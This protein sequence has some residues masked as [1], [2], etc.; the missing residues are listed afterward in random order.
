MTEKEA[1]Y[2]GKCEDD[3]RSKKDA[4]QMGTGVISLL[5]VRSKRSANESCDEHESRDYHGNGH[6]CQ[7]EPLNV[8]NH[9]SCSERRFQPTGARAA[10][11]RGFMTSLLAHAGGI[12]KQAAERTGFSVA[13]P[14]RRANEPS[15]VPPIPRRVQSTLR[16]MPAMGANVS[17]H[18]WSVEELIDAALSDEDENRLTA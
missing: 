10:V 12:A 16:C 17:D 2:D 11:W 18:I 15:D 4:R 5:S 1:G 3:R 8:S 6:D 7:D 14:W 9:A 13:S